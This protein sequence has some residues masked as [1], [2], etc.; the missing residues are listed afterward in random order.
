MARVI[1]VDDEAPILMVLKNILESAGHTV[2][3]FRDPVQAVELLKTEKFDVLISDLRM[4]GI[5]GMD[6]LKSSRTLRPEM[7]VVLMTGYGS[8]KTAAEALKLDVFDYISKPFRL[9]EFITTIARAIEYGQSHSSAPKT[10]Q[11]VQQGELFG[12]MI[13]CSPSMSALCELIKRVAVTDTPLLVFGEVGTGKSL[14]AKMIHT[15]S[16]RKDS[17]FVKVNCTAVPEEEF[18]SRVFDPASGSL[19]AA[20]AGTILFEEVWAMPQEAQVMLLKTLDHSKPDA[21]AA[22]A[23]TPHGAR[24]LAESSRDLECMVHGDLF[25]K[26]LY[27]RLTVIRMDVKPLRERRED[28]MP[29]VAHFMR[30][31][32][33]EGKETPA[34]TSEVQAIFAHYDWPGNIEE[35]ED[36]I[37]HMQG[38]AAG[39]QITKA[40]LPAHI[41]DAVH[42]TE[43]PAENQDKF[44]AKSLREFLRRQIQSSK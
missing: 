4:T 25:N 24:V 35:V 22:T 33:G 31:L 29:I 18:V 28:I 38:K 44:R 10:G 23:T 11:E 42:L 5:S 8:V 21:G 32:L 15:H 1:L 30:Q 40:A 43:F 39:K 14:V 37:R 6:V 7:P 26:D 12:D 3:T 20:N 13:V 27:Y 36:T 17:P 19:A 41:V 34:M 2:L 9:D 16:L